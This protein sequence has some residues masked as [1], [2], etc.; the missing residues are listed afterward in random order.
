MTMSIREQ[1][2]NTFWWLVAVGI[3]VYLV[4]GAYNTITVM[5]E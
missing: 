5:L 3:T 1:L 2:S 4:W